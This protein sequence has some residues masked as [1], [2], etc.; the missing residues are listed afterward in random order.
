MINELDGEEVYIDTDSERVY[1][2][3]KQIHYVKC[4]KRLNKH[5]QLEEDPTFGVSP[6]L[7]MIDRFLDTHV[8]DENEIIVTPH[9]T[10]PFITLRTILNASEKLKQGH[11]S[12]QACTSHQEFA[13]YKNQPINFDPNVVQK[14]QNLEP[15]KLGNGAFFIFTKKTFKKNNNR[16]GENPFLYPIS[17]P[18]SIEID[19]HEDLLLARM[20]AND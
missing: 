17:M 15:V 2:D 1:Q 7:L 5:I 14:T 19:T 8:E 10:S 3:C 16:T 9:V 6:A 12:V 13:Y 11:D 18:E 4:Y 20:W